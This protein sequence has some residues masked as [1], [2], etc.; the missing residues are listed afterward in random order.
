MEE[1]LSRDTKII[2]IISSDIGTI[3][4]LDGLM[5]DETKADKLRSILAQLEYKHQVTT[6]NEHGVPF[7]TYMYIPE[8]HPITNSIS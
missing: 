2:L 5:K 6:W 4:L 8:T 7:C 3:T 1:R